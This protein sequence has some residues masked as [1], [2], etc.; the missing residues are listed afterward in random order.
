M[1]V[2]AENGRQILSLI[3]VFALLGFAVWKL[4]GSRISLLSF[5]GLSFKNSLLKW[6]PKRN[7]EKEIRSLERLALTPQHTLHLVNFSGQQLLIATHPHGVTLVTPP[8][9]ARS[10][11]V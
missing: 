8:R 10:A 7:N 2:V 11:Q 5:K 6:S 1:D 4:G 3:I 9:Q